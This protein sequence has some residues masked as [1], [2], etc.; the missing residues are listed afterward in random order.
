MI[1]HEWG[2]DPELEEPAMYWGALATVHSGKN[3]GIEIPW[4]RLCY[5]GASDDPEKADFY[6]WLNERGIPSLEAE[7]RRG[8]KRG[9]T[10]FRWQLVSRDGRFKMTAET[11]EGEANICIGAWRTEVEL[12]DEPPTPAPP[13]Q[14]EVIPLDRRPLLTI[15]EAAQYFSIGRAKLY[16][17]VKAPNCKFVLFVGNKAMIKRE[18]FLRFIEASYSI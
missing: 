13:Q 17:L 12:I 11:G 1:Q 5:V 16:E 8:G 9:L 4:N 15:A 3:G 6:A 18:P 7:I 2:M 14:A 10:A